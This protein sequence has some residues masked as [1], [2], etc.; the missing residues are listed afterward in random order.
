MHGLALG[1]DRASELWCAS[2]VREGSL[3]HGMTNMDVMLPKKE[4]GDIG[5][6]RRLGD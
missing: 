5:Q 1:I 3:G 4:H 6:Y 2:H